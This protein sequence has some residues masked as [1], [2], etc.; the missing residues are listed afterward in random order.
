MK[1]LMP[2]LVYVA[3]LLFFFLLAH[4]KACEEVVGACT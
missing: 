3:A 1:R 4:W 2:A